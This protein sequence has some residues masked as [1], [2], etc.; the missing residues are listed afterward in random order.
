ML[1]HCMN[2]KCSESFF[3]VKFPAIV[4][5]NNT[6][7]PPPKKK[8]R[9]EL[10]SNMHAILTPLSDS[11]S[12]RL[13]LASVSALCTFFHLV[14]VSRFLCFYACLSLHLSFWIVFVSSCLSVPPSL[15]LDC[16][17][18][19]LPMSLSLCVCLSV[20]LC[21][22]LSVCLSVSVCVCLCLSVSVCV[23]LCL[24][25]SV[26]VC[27]C[28]SVSVCVYAGNMRRWNVKPGSA[29]VSYGSVG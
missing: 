18:L 15:F 26:C 5:K 25:V 13:K 22:S 28:L 24:S 14:S 10:R 17:C 20:C 2:E 12:V 16:L 11:T 9:F 1:L 7:L 8:I 27:L 23:C 4:T 3:A 6:A 21:L 29:S 19:F